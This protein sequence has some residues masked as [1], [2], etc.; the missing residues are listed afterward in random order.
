MSLD[1]EI[2]MAT[3]PDG[4][5]AL[6]TTGQGAPILVLH[7]W[8]GLNETIRA[9]CRRLAAAGFVAFAP[10]LYHGQITDKI[11][12]AERLAK[13]NFQRA[14]QVKGEITAAARFLNKRSDQSDAGIATIGFSMGASYAVDLSTTS[15]ELVRSVVLF[16]GAGEGEY[17]QSQS[18]YLGHFAKNDQYE[19]EEYIVA[20]EKGMRAA[21]RPVTFHTYP[22]TGHWFFESDRIDAFNQEASDL[23][24]ERT[25]AF[26]KQS[27]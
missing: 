24:W 9:F 25:L 8:W 26:L 12:E 19:E 7:A 1:K 6:P 27:S 22:E 3:Q 17:S 4:Y 23:A 2:P 14:E 13:A 15:P 18:S 5:L 21:G 10:D 11:E 20:M 16:Y